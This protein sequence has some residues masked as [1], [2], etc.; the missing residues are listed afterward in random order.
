VQSF[1]P[2][3]CARNLARDTLDLVATAPIAA[4]DEVTIDYRCSLW[5][6]PQ[7]LKVP[8]SG[9]RCAPQRAAARPAA[10]ADEPTTC[11]ASASRCGR[12]RQ[13]ALQFRS[14]Q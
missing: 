4:G 9:R 6:E 8:L 11:L 5:F 13:S 1:A 12:N 14:R 3:E 7:E 10:G 2:A